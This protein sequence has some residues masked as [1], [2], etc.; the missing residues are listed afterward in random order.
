MIHFQL[1]SATGVKFDDE[2]YEVLVPTKDG[3]VAV[4]ED[5]MPLISAG[6][7]GVLSV[8]KKAEDSD[9]ELEDFAV[10]GG[11]LQADGKTARF[12]TED[13]TAADEISEQE[14][15][16]AL[17]RAQKLVSAA[18][19][20]EDLREAQSVMHHHEVRLNLARLKRRHHQ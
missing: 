11:V 10:Y 13:V 19:T 3:V 12:V 14:S 4:F 18:G 6:V 7:P 5:H 1:I 9:Q 17:E 20:R 16:E 2:A 15:R 8:R